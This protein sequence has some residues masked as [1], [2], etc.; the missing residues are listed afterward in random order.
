MLQLCR[1]FAPAPANRQT[2]PS[3]QPASLGL[4]SDRRGMAGIPAASLLRCWAARFS[5]WEDNAAACALLQGW[6]LGA[7]QGQ[8]ASVCA[9][10]EKLD[11]FDLN[12][13]IRAI[14][15]DEIKVPTIPF[16]LPTA[17]TYTGLSEMMTCELD[18]LKATVLS[19]SQAPVI[20]Y[21]DM[22]MEEMAKD[23]EFPKKWM[24]GWALC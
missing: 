20:M 21:S 11:G 4:L 17:R 22:P 13:Y 16:Q 14:H 7:D 1:A 5:R 15:F 3:L 10:L 18:F 24:Y 6:L 19:K 12:E 2:R 8:Q 23:P 9:F